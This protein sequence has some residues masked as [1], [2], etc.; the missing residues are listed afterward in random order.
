[1]DLWEAMTDDPFLPT[2]VYL[3]H[4]HNIIIDPDSC[5]FCAEFYTTLERAVNPERSRASIRHHGKPKRREEKK[6]K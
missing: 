6:R 4:L 5:I 1:M 3:L 2:S